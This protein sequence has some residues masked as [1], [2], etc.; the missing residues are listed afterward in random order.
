LT[1]K[2]GGGSPTISQ[3]EI[4]KNHGISK[5]REVA[6]VRADNIPAAPWARQ[7]KRITPTRDEAGWPSRS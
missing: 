7:W 2:N 1:I 5:D 4:A 3:R 6:A